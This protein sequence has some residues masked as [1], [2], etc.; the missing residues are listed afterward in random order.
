MQNLIENFDVEIWQKVQAKFASLIDL[1]VFTM[2]SQGREQITSTRFPTFCNIVKSTPEGLKRCQNCRK[3]QHAKMQKS[4]EK[5]SFYHCHAGLLNIMAPIV[6]DNQH[7][8][9]VV[10][11]SITQTIKDVSAIKE[12]SQAIQVN[13]QELEEHLT[14]IPGKS[15]AE[16]EKYGSLVYAMSQTVPD[17]ISEKKKTEKKV[18]ELTLLQ[19]LS[20]KMNS[21]FDM[22]KIV[23]ALMEFLKER[24]HGIFSSI[25]I[26][27]EEEVKCYCQDTIMVNQAYEK[28]LLTRLKE[29]KK[30]I[31]I[32][33][34]SN[35]PHYKLANMPFSSAVLMPLMI[36]DK[37]IGAFIFYS[38]KPDFIDESSFKLLSILSDQAASAITN[39]QQYSKINQ[40]AITDKLTGLYNRRYFMEMLEKEITRSKQFFKPISIILFDIDHFGKYNNAHGHPQGDKL[41]KSL[42]DLCKAYARSVDI[43][44]RYGGEEFIVIMP[45]ADEE[46]TKIVA[47]NIRHAI[48]AEPFPGRETQPGGKTYSICW[49]FNFKN[50]FS[51]F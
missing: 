35:D 18:D 29:D 31:Q 4:K 46:E 14:S 37:P 41:L 28:L 17:L 43:V 11:S 33:D 5:I 44:G 15:N 34:L 24:M 22:Y 9:S 8:G 30:V 23:T 10:C 49:C 25:I 47:E 21:T 45:E 51:Y 20:Q 42:A 3:E 6:I 1:P 7:V 40:L 2:D 16:I 12:L 27:G 13:K 38:D 32:N 26:F 19:K 48:E 36:H 50:P 39:S